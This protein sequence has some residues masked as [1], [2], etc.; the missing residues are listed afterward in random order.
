MPRRG[1]CCRCEGS[2]STGLIF[3]GRRNAL[4]SWLTQAVTPPSPLPDPDERGLPTRFSVLRPWLEWGSGAARR[5]RG[6][7]LLADL[8]A[9]AISVGADVALFL[10][11][12]SSQVLQVNRFLFGFSIGYTAAVTLTD[13]ELLQEMS[14]SLFGGAAQASAALRLTPVNGNSQLGSAF[15]ANS[16]YFSNNSVYLL[17]GRLTPAS[18]QTQLFARRAIS[19]NGSTRLVQPFV[20]SDQI[21]HTF[22]SIEILTASP[23]DGVIV[24]TAKPQSL[25]EFPF[26]WGGSSSSPTL[27]WPEALWKP[28]FSKN[29]LSG[30]GGSAYRAAIYRDG[31]LVETVDRT[32]PATPSDWAGPFAGHTDEDGSYLL[33][34]DSNAGLLQGFLS[35]VIDRTP[36]IG[37]FE[38]V[39]DFFE[40][41]PTN[42]S[43]FSY[44]DGVGAVRRFATENTRTLSNDGRWESGNFTRSEFSRDLSGGNHTL[45]YP[46]SFFDEVGNPMPTPLPTAQFQVHE[47]PDDQKYGAQ[48]TLELPP[49]DD[50]LVYDSP[51]SSVS[52]TFNRQVSGLRK[53][54][55]TVEGK[56]AAGSAISLPFTLSGDGGEIS[57]NATGGGTTFML[58]LD[59]DPEKQGYNTSWLVVFD[60]RSGGQVFAD[61]GSQPPEPC[62]LRSRRSWLIRQDPTPGRTLIDTRS[63][64]DTLVRVP[65]VT[66]TLAEAALPELPGRNDSLIDLSADIVLPVTALLPDVPPMGCYEQ[67]SDFFPGD[68]TNASGLAWN[69]E[70][71]AEIARVESERTTP[72]PDGENTPPAWPGTSTVSRALESASEPYTIANQG[73][74]RDVEGIAM[75]GPPT[76]Q[77]RVHAI[78][79]GQKFGAHA[80][81]SIE[82][83]S[84]AN[85]GP[86]L[87]GAVSFLTITFNRAIE[88]LTRSM[89]SVVGTRDNGQTVE[90]AFRLYQGPLF[91]LELVD[92]DEGFGTAFSLWLE[93][94]SQQVPNSRWLVTL[95]PGSTLKVP[96]TG[97][98]PEEP[99]RLV[100]RRSWLI[101]QTEDPYADSS[102][103]AWYR[104]GRPSPFAPQVPPSLDDATDVPYSYF[105]L[106]TTVYPSPPAVLTCPAPGAAQ[107]HSSLILGGGGIT[108]LTVSVSGHE[109]I[110]SPMTFSASLNGEPCSQNVW[111]NAG[112]GGAG[113][114]GESHYTQSRWLSQPISYSGGQLLYGNNPAGQVKA[115]AAAQGNEWVVTATTGTAVAGRAAAT[116]SALQTTT[117][118]QLTIRVDARAFGSGRSYFGNFLTLNGGPAAYVEADP[119]VW[120]PE[121]SGI[122]SELQAAIGTAP[123]GAIPPQDPGLLALYIAWRDVPEDKFPGE[124]EA[125]RLAARQAFVTARDNYLSART[126]NAFDRPWP[127]SVVEL[128]QDESGNINPAGNERSIGVLAGGGGGATFYA[129]TP[130]GDWLPMGN[131]IRILGPEVDGPIEFTKAGYAPGSYPG[132][133]VETTGPSQNSIPTASLTFTRQQEETLASGGSV[134]FT[135]GNLVY[136]ISAS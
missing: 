76:A 117:L 34:F 41:D 36:P 57:G 135:V 21:Q 43:G 91:S 30:L 9:N 40:G 17:A 112:N 96:E 60:P 28:L 66:A 122:T 100:A 62:V 107:P 5:P 38:Q 14:V 110:A 65:T 113:A 29:P 134:Q 46:G 99:C 7:S 58:A 37:C 93:Q 78:P 53:G 33:Q 85:K 89:I 95:T 87:R 18:D 63:S 104:Y 55:F 47:I 31:E 105:G 69:Q 11:R 52:V 67:V 106:S 70:G 20:G 92:D 120:R 97:G 45:S 51:V 102:Q 88:G 12:P 133:Y 61:A 19:M 116:Y 98:L 64:G 50:S 35:F 123:E 49:N 128:S 23:D 6:G 56:N 75:P 126:L 3:T 90:A 121:V 13:A 72:E 82:G 129:S 4:L 10:D 24:A 115:Y 84:V 77:F 111:V 26:G 32:P 25:V 114:A 109:Y 73:T 125:Q 1:N 132:D 2:C 22:N 59:T 74:F 130:L 101:Q 136:T 54:M 81:I 80:W 83:D 44:S 15:N 108:S 79:T 39:N 94:P 42:A 86:M 103:T 131:V 127:P 124:N 118:G 16:T 48:A 119:K 68:P 71:F 27:I 8:Q